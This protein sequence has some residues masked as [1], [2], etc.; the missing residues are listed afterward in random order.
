MQY[1]FTTKP[2]RAGKDAS[3]ID[4]IGLSPQAPK[5][6]KDGFSLIPMW[7]ADMNFVGFPGIG[8]SIIGRVNHPAFGYF[9]PR[10]EY[11]GS[12]IRWQKVR[13]GVEGLRPEHIGYENGVLGGVI[14]ALGVLC[15]R[16]DN[17]LVH[18]PTYIGFT[19]SLANSGYHIVHS[20]LIPDGRNVL[21]MDFDDMEKKIRENDIHAMIFCSPHNPCGRVWEEQEL[22]MLSELCGK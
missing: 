14:S 5:P 15:S 13:N 1:D 7:V 4:S 17:V 16:G 19:G 20:E 8:E 22:R 21:R 10:K 3:A 9:N 11:Y 2:D 6:P 12:I 18:S